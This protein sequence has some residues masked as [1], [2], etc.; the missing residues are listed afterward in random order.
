M[1]QNIDEYSAPPVPKKSNSGLIIGICVGCGCLGGL[2]LVVGILIALLLPAIT[3]ARSAAQRMQCNNNEKQIMFALWNYHD[4]HGSFPPAYTVDEDGNP[5]HSWR[6]LILPYMEQQLLY[7]Q[8]RLDEPWDSPHNQQFHRQMP[9]HYICQDAPLESRIEGLTS[10]KWVV[11]PGTIS[12]GPDS[13]TFGEMQNGTSN[14]IAI[15]EVIPSTNWM[16]PVD[17]PLSEISLGMNHSPTEG[18]GS[19]HTGGINVGM[20]DGSTRFVSTHDGIVEKS[21]LTGKPIEETKKSENDDDADFD[22]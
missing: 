6:V 13:M 17:I 3:A 22:H 14:T 9:F 20:C 12:S 16:A 15:V 18:V 10:Y 19:F 2:L 8:I 5:L 21:F 7:N 4:T 11:G 1:S